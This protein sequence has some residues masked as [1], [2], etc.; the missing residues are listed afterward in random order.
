LR[1]AHLGS[2]VA[3]SCFVRPIGHRHPFLVCDWAPRR[4]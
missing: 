1:D 3:R 4:Y 2:P